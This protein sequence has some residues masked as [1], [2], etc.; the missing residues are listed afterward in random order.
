MDRNLFK[1]MVK[2]L[3]ILILAHIAS[4]LIFGIVFSGSIGYLYED[5]PTRAKIFVVIYNIV[6]DAIFV[7]LCSKLESSYVEYRKTMKESLK[8]N[9]FSVLGHFK[10]A[11]F[12][13]HIIKI[14][15]FMAFQIP[16]VIFF[17]L[18]GISLQYPIVFEQFYYMDAG[19]YMLTGSA[20]LGWLLNTIIFGVI[21][22][23]IRLLF[24]II[25]KKDVEKDIII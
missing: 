22:T 17:S 25:T 23:L 6:F 24:I 13:E 9:S 14:A 3:G 20:I 21:F 5:E 11:F 4:M 19:C 15:I 12:K 18:F 8:N 7:A 1:S 10:T 2:W 16:F